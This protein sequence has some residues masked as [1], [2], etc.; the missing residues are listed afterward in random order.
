MHNIKLTIAYDGADFHGWQIQPGQPTIQGVLTDLL[1]QLTSAQTEEPSPTLCGAGRTDAG[2]HAW[3]QVANFNTC[4]HLAPNEFARALNALLPPTIRIRQA[5][6]AVPDFH[7]R[8]QAIAKTYRYRIYRGPVVPPFLWR[9]VLHHPYPLDFVAM[10]EA[11]R[12]FQG[13][14]DFT[15][16]AASS[17][18]EEEDS[19]RLTLRSILSSEMLNMSA[20]PDGETLPANCAAANS[21]ARHSTIANSSAA[22]HLISLDNVEWVYEVR[23]RSFLRN[24]VRIIVGTLLE[25]GRG[26]LTPRDVPRLLALADRTASG[27]TVP[28]QGLCLMS[29]EYHDAAHDSER[30]EA[31]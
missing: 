14:H 30:G 6:E 27:P 3:G 26:R 22:P 5:E 13:E 17:G 12:L 21:P 28:P 11:A 20:A 8:H 16:F 2:V 15:S 10:A 7:A 23:G 4:S 25:V 31:Q 24:M 19:E 18:S 1:C 9:Y 29:V